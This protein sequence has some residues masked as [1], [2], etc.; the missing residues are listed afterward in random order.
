VLQV[1]LAPGVET[2]TLS[3]LAVTVWT[4]TSAAACMMECGCHIITGYKADTDNHI[5]V[6]FLRGTI[7]CLIGGSVPIWFCVCSVSMLQ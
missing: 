4:E 5:S 7:I 1:T 3:A 6:K 2:P